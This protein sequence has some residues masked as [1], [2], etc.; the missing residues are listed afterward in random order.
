MKKF[1]LATLVAATFFGIGMSTDANARLIERYD[2]AVEYQKFDPNSMHTA[3]AWY[4]EHNGWKE[5]SY[6]YGDGTE[7][8]VKVDPKG[9]AYEVHTNH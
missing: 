5:Y 4:H 8:L 7:I 2:G 9:W 3:L 1:L 6:I